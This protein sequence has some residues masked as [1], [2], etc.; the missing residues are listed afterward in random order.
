MDDLYET[1][2]SVN[3]GLINRGL[4]R[5]EES[6]RG[7]NYT[8]F[9]SDLLVVA[10]A[11][12]AMGLTR[13]LFPNGHP[14]LIPPGVFSNNSIQSADQGV[15]VKATRGRGPAVDMHA[16]RRAWYCVFRYA[17]D[18]VTEPIMAREPTRFT[19]I[20]LAEL[21]AEDFRHNPR[22]SPAS[23]RTTTPN[24][25]GATKLRAGLLYLG[26]GWPAP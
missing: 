12:H 5:I 26:D 24:A 14:D 20:W 3:S 22:L 10:I 9:V 18:E 2:Y 17:V 25:Q 16:G 13:N 15:E 23:T 6:L 19:H 11:N 1:I 21:E 8:A 4:L 7:A